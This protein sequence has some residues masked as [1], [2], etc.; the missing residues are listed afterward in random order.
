MR[1]RGKV[2]KYG[3]NIDTDVIFPGRYTYRQMEPE[4]MAK[5]AFCDLDP[6]FTKKVKPGD[7]LV[8][9]WN[10]GMGSSR[11]QAALSI[12]YAGIGAIIAK[13]FSR[14]FFRNAINAGLP[15]IVSPEA[16]ESLEEG[17][18]VE[19]HLEKGIIKSERGKFK[20]PPL[21]KDILEI[22]KD[23]GLIPHTKKKLG[24]KE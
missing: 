5:Y 24:K 2:L 10:F 18:E 6:D 22:L 14:I 19:I 11:E 16:V 13:S 21:R 4:E 7:V 12:K 23:G 20:F 8:A 9:G 3:D 17:D 1:I 15:V